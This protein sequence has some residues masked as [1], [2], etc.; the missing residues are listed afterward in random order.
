MTDISKALELAKSFEKL[1]RRFS[2][3]DP[4]KYVVSVLMAECGSAAAA[5]RAL[6]AER[7]DAE[8]RNAK[9]VAENDRLKRDQGHARHPLPQRRTHTAIRAIHNHENGMR[10]GLT[11]GLGHYV[12]CRL[13]EVFIDPDSISLAPLL[14]DVAILISLALQHGAS[15]EKMRDSITRREDGTTPVSIIGSSIDAVAGENKQ[16]AR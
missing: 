11:I 9:L 13:G 7:D 14:R 12:D 4:K 6:V 3:R 16:G 10:D 5:I 1:S 15:I 2:D 8:A